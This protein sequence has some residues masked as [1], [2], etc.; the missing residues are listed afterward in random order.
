MRDH[1]GN[2]D[3]A[4]QHFGGDTGDWI[5]LSTGINRCP[6]PVPHLQPHHWTALPTHSDKAAL[7]DAARQAYSTDAAV[8]A[9]AGAQA[10]IQMIPLCFSVGKARVL[11]PTYN[12]HASCLRSAGWDVVEVSSLAALA[13]ADLAVVV[14]PNNPNGT[15]HAPADLLSVVGNVGRLVVDESFADPEPQLSVASHAGRLD[16]LVLRSFG[17]FYGLAGMRLGFVLGCAED[18][19]QLSQMAGPWPVSGS[20]IE[21]GRVA[22]GD[23]NWAAAT[24][25]RLMT[26]VVRL[27]ELAKTAGWS[28]VGGTQLFCLYETANA[29]AAQQQLAQS[30][31][32]SRIFPWS[33]TWVRLGLPGSEQEWTR[34]ATALETKP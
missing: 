12:E 27:D 20:A 17:K 2:L 18:I 8:L 30:H 33:A 26:D 28:R 25:A 1:G 6:Y 15:R 22:L 10:A 9:T 4:V 34:L 13:G 5:D 16:L 29:K 23:R 24:T 14:N 11:G 7:A 21:I 3:W 31:I 19:A 32:W